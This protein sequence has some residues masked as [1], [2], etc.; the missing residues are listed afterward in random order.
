MRG[1]RNSRPRLSG[2][3][4]HG[5]GH[6][7]K[8]AELR[9]ANATEGE[10]V[11][12]L[13]DEAFLDELTGTAGLNGVTIRVIAANSR[14]LNKNRGVAQ[15]LMLAF[16]EGQYRTYTSEKQM[17]AYAKRWKLNYDDVKDSAQDVLLKNSTFLPVA[18]L[19]VINQ[20]ALENKK[21]KKLLTS[22]QLKELVHPFGNKPE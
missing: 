8:G 4:P 14:W 7:K 12:D 2:E 13:T 16:T 15:R 10:S 3:L 1:H 20:V 21:I 6:R 9:V 19:D 18:R 17:R 5:W 11:N 22:A